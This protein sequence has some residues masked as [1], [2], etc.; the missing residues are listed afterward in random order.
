V[1]GPIRLFVYGSLKRGFRHHSVLSGAELEGEASTAAGY[2]LVRY[3]AYPALVTGGERRV[4]GELYRVELDDLPRL[5][6]F[7]GVPELYRRELV[8]LEDGSEA[9]AYFAVHSGD[10]EELA[11]GAWDE[12]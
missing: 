1:S 6:A 5:D 8:R 4:L 2:R 3:G 10:F 11:G 7:E 9:H 12:S